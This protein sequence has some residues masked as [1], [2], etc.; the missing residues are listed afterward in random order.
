MKSV[1]KNYDKNLIILQEKC[2][3]LAVLIIIKKK[4]EK[5]N[6]LGSKKGLIPMPEGRGSYFDVSI[7]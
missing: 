2:T 3:K 5:S 1:R 4:F 7:R 6:V